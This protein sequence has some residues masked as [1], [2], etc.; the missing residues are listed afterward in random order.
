[1]GMSG[2]KASPE[3]ESW[4]AEFQ[5]AYYL[6]ISPLE[7]GGLDSR[8]VGALLYLLKLTKEKEAE[9]MRRK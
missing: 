7:L 5:A 4:M 6:H 8:R 1:M 3:T 9:A 2:L